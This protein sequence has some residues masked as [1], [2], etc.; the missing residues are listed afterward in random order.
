MSAAQVA[1]AVMSEPVAET[2]PSL[3]PTRPVLPIERNPLATGPRIS[4]HLLPAALAGLNEH[5]VANGTAP[6]SFRL[7]A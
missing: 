5:Q 1:L 2:E 6:V 7:D 3:T 4:V